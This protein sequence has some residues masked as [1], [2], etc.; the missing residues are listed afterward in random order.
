M[1]NFLVLGFPIASGISGGIGDLVDRHSLYANTSIGERTS[2][3]YRIQWYR[4][5]IPWCRK[6]WYT[7]RKR[8]FDLHEESIYSA[9][10]ARTHPDVYIQPRCNLMAN[11]NKYDIN[12]SPP[13]RTGRCRRRVTGRPNAVTRIKNGKEKWPTR[14]ISVR[15]ELLARYI[16][17]SATH[18]ACWEG[19]KARKRRLHHEFQLRECRY[20][21]AF[22]RFPYFRRLV[23][24]GGFFW[25]FPRECR[26][27]RGHICIVHLCVLFL[28]LSFNI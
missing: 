10:P 13:H 27:A 9:I 23:A 3:A 19:R 20:Q 4:C 11:L 14:A 15:I 26:R 2:L 18:R 7:I 28:S 1:G 17:N 22:R 5:A 25:H 6:Y 12:P 24:E 8:K 21:K 16:V